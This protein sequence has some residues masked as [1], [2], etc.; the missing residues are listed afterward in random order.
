M[1]KRVL[2]MTIRARLFAVFGLM[3]AILVAL[4][5]GGIWGL[6]AANADMEGLY[7]DRL[8]PVTQLARINDLSRQTL[9]QM[10]IATIMHGGTEA[11]RKYLDRVAAND[12]EVETLLDTYLQSNMTDEER[13]LV[14]Q[15]REK[16]RIFVTK[17][18]KPS[19]AALADGS[20]TDAEDT[21]LG[22]AMPN[23]ERAQ[24][25]FDALIAKQVETAEATY[26]HSHRRGQVAAAVGVTGAI[27]SLL[28]AIGMAAFTSRSVSHPIQHLT[29]A[30][31]AIAD[32]ALDH[33]VDGRER[34][35]EVG[36]MAAAL[37]VFRQHALERQ[38]LAEKDHANTLRRERRAEK[39]EE[40][41]RRFESEITGALAHIRTEV[42]HLHGLAETLS[43]TAEQTRQRSAAVAVATEQATASVE[44]V[45][46]AGV[47]LMSSIHEISRHVLRSAAVTGGAA[48]EA[49]DTNAKIGGLTAAAKKIGEIVNLINMIASQTN[50]L[51]LNATI[52][53][54]RAGEAGK[55]FAVVAH[56][57]K[58]L[59]G[60]TARATEDIAAQVAAV[61]AETSGAVLAIEGIAR[62]I[63]QINDMA[64]VISS[65]VE[66]QGAATAEIARTADQTSTA[67]R[68]VATN[69]ADVAAAAAET[70][71]MARMVFQAA[72]GLQADGGHLEAEV[73][74]FLEEVRA[75]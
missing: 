43:A 34:G 71:R 36:K 31:G 35:D 67:T 12:K 16:R 27:V 59:A 72:E 75:A 3:A 68:Q 52:E 55:G 24:K 22:V 13:N 45:S 64:T 14:G 42:G 50:L 73:A 58:G 53:S 10:V 19:I 61:Q 23:Y 33:P 41:T 65:A 57:V 17:G 28:L 74:R 7:R 18:M 47:E 56:E 2:D 69:I 48:T 1:F 38:R 62:T 15:W 9:Q 46:A 63:A 39:I 60:Q 25:V 51:A 66:E 11:T 6:S 32:G 49:A 20:F 30:M 37:E 54:A 26:G 5:A 40:M 29:T 70:G 8:V 4:T 44:S 21:I